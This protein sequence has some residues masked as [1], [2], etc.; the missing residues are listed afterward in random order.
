MKKL[1]R[2]SISAQS[3]FLIFEIHPS[4]PRVVIKINSHPL[5]KGG[6]EL[7]KKR[8][9]MQPHNPWS[10]KSYPAG[11]CFFKVNN[12]NCETMCEMCSKFTIKT[13]KNVILSWL[14]WKLNFLELTQK[15]SARLTSANLLLKYVE[16]FTRWV[17]QTLILTLKCWEISLRFHWEI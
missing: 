10:C 3:F 14:T 9:T 16:S 7:C 15:L 12:G 17:P 13:P 11:I 4:P 2:K 8:Y 1:K 6:V 5:K